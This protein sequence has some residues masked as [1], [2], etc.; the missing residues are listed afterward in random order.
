MD[1]LEAISIA[2]KCL[3]CPDE[4]IAMQGITLTDRE[5]AYDLIAEY[6]GKIA[7]LYKNK[8]AT[9][10]VLGALKTLGDNNEKI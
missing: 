5:K 8:G 4:V 3:L 9:E 1:L 6:H 10:E 7:L 2:R